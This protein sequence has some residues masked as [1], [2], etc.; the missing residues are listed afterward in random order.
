MNSRPL[1]VPSNDPNDFPALTPAH[2]LIG[3]PLLTVPD[4][5]LPDSA[6]LSLVRRFQQREHAMNFFW[7]R[8]SREYLTTLQQRHKWTEEQQNLQIRDIVFL[9]DDNTPPMMWPW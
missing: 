4:I 1:T 3:R 5:K 7:K 2:L 9:K 8:W 6:D